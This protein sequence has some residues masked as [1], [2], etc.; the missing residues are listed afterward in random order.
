MAN[1]LFGSS[2]QNE[3][4]KFSGSNIVKTTRSRYNGLISNFFLS[5]KLQNEITLHSSFKT[6]LKP[7]E[8]AQLDKHL[9]DDSNS[10]GFH[11]W[12]SPYFDFPLPADSFHLVKKDKYLIGL[13]LYQTYHKIH[14]Q[15]IDL[16]NEAEIKNNYNHVEG[17]QLYMNH[18]QFLH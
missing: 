13:S 12:S 3:S 15:N 1:M 4:V 14:F 16:L 17:D 8:N 5:M 7:V 9:F 2:R 10:N 11:D 18:N 6:T